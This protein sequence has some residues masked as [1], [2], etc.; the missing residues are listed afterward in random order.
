M[1]IYEIQMK[2]FSEK[3]GLLSIAEFP[4]ELPFAP[5]RIFFI[6]GVPV[7]TV[8]GEH[9]HKTT[10]QAIFCISGGVSLRFHNGQ[11]WESFSLTNNGVGLFIP[12]LH[13]GELSGFTPDA[14]VLV[15]AS[16]NY[17]SNEYIND[18]DSFLT[19]FARD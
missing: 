5:V 3:R 16:E 4:N 13:W 1:A 9:A 18:F 19:Y 2:T 17:S 6:Q 7:N 10:E 11:T 12:A 14:R 15:L 8:R